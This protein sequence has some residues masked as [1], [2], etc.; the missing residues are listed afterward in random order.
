MIDL[1]KG[2][3]VCGAKTTRYEA[4]TEDND[5]SAAYECGA[6][7][8]RECRKVYF[9]SECVLT[10]DEADMVIGLLEVIADL[11]ARLTT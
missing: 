2:C 6:D 8:W 10:R 5:E 7:V 1:Q 9:Q 11:R 3:P 4:E